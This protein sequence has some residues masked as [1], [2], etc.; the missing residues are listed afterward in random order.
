MNKLELQVR[1]AYGRER[2]Y[3]MNELARGLCALSGMKTFADWQLA[4]LERLGYLIEW[5][6]LRPE[7]LREEDE[8]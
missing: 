1:H 8:L 4:V 5:V 3:P 2:I 6:P 7:H